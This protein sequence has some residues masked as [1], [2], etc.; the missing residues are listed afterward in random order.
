MK[1]F[2]KIQMI[3]CIIPFY[4]LI[5]VFITSYVYCYKSH[6]NYLKLA[7][8]GAIYFVIYIWLWNYLSLINIVVS[9]IICGI[10][11]LLGNY[12]LVRIQ[13]DCIKKK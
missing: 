7:I 9:T 12:F 11:S 4:S 3:S 6:K 2:Q 8:T 5:F 1:L 13:V 10:I